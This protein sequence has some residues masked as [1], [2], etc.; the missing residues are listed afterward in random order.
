MIRA[1][2]L[3]AELKK[4]IRKRQLPDFILVKLQDWIEDVEDRGLEEVRKIPGYHDEPLSGDLIGQRSIRLGKGWRAYYRIGKD[5][6]EFVSVERI[7]RHEYG[8]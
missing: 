2:R 1:V 5:H 3:G 7:D 6:V 4:Q 8:K